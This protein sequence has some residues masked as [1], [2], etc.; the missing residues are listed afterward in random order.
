MGRI[1]SI[2]TNKL[3]F[4]LFTSGIIKKLLDVCFEPNMSK[5]INLKNLQAYL[6]NVNWMILIT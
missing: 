2:V 4:S 3:L 1:P 5:L 6:V